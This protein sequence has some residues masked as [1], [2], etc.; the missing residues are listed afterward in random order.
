M[1]KKKQR[2]YL[3]PLRS[4][5]FPFPFSRPSFSPSAQTGSLAFGAFVQRKLVF[6]EIFARFG[7]VARKA[8]DVIWR[9]WGWGGG[10]LPTYPFSPPFHG[11]LASLPSHGFSGFLDFRFLNL[12]FKLFA[13]FVRVY[14]MAKSN[15][16][17]PRLQIFPFGS[18]FNS[19]S[20][21][22]FLL[23][24]IP[25]GKGFYGLPGGVLTSDKKKLGDALLRDATDVDFEETLGTLSLYLVQLY[26]SRC[27]S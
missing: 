22:H 6:F 3:D 21:T 15:L 4:P 25:S 18:N 2:A 8:K 23:H 24:Q 13:W 11:V 10:P 20:F 16:D 5:R 14:K 7:L 26:R 1:S 27:T 9:G 19:Y 17:D 12:I